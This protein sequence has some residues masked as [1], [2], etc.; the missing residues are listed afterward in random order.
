MI[1]IQIMLLK[2]NLSILQKVLSKIPIFCKKV[3]AFWKNLE[4]AKN[5]VTAFFT[6]C[7]EKAVF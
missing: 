6:L 4:P 1:I 5:Q 2:N 3:A 7:S